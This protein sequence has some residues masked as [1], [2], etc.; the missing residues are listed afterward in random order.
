MI[1]WR[2]EVTGWGLT[3]DNHKF[4]KS[5]S[6]KCVKITFFRGTLTY[7]SVQQ[8]HYQSRCLAMSCCETACFKS[9]NSGKQRDKQ[10]AASSSSVPHSA[11]F[12]TVSYF[13]W[14][15]TNCQLTQ[16]RQ[17]NQQILYS[18]RAS[19]ITTQMLTKSAYTKIMLGTVH[20]LK[21][22]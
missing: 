1:F 22:T 18:T 21:H 3:P 9:S 17:I 11:I 8:L 4:Q 2:S 19:V 16:N 12:S 14:P 20:C 10:R 13:F 5:N 7:T 6:G 15:Y